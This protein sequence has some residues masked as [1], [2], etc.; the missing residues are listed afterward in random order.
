MSDNDMKPCGCYG[1]EWCDVCHPRVCGDCRAKDKEIK[2]LRAELDAVHDMANDILSDPH[3]RPCDCVPGKRITGDGLYM[4]E[5]PVMQNHMSDLR[6]WS[7]QYSHEREAREN[8]GDHP[9]FNGWKLVDHGT[10]N[11]KRPDC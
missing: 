10:L 11:G 8:K 5:H 2:R 4:L 6:E 9:E 3:F 7:V 1:D